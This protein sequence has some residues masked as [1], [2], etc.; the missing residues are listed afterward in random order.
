[1]WNFEDLEELRKYHGCIARESLIC[2]IF[3]F[4]LLSTFH[5]LTNCHLYTLYWTKRH[6]EQRNCERQNIFNIF[7]MNHPQSVDFQR[8]WPK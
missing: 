1:M 8:D 6:G 7:N 3:I 2:C 4:S 5:S